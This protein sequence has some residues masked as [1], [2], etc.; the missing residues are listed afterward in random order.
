M[1]SPLGSSPQSKNDERLRPLSA[2][3][4]QILAGKWLPQRNEVLDAVVLGFLCE[5]FNFSYF[6][7]LVLRLSTLISLAGPLK[8]PAF[9]LHAET[10]NQQIGIFRP[11]YM[12]M[13]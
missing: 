9:R 10:N 2:S 12:N 4:A 5:P 7:S 11:T 13:M 3:R 8:D 6:K 1:A